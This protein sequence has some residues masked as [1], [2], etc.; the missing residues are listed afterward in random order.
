[1][2]RRWQPAR[3]GPAALCDCWELRRFGAMGALD[4]APTDAELRAG[5]D[6]ALTH[7]SRPFHVIAGLSA[8]AARLVE[9]ST[10]PHGEDGDPARAFQSLV[11]RYGDEHR[12]A[13]VGTYFGQ[14]PR[15]EASD[16]TR[17]AAIHDHMTSAL[18][19]AAAEPLAGEAGWNRDAMWAR[20]RAAESEAAAAVRAGS[21][22]VDGEPIPGFTAV[23]GDHRRTYFA[24]PVGGAVF[25]HTCRWDGATELQRSHDYA[26]ID[27]AFRH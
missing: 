10:W 3:P 7:E 4:P 2:L 15:E 6:H 22:V 1:M 25:V 16:Q 13:E 21:L 20:I 24:V 8:G 9:H 19:L 18:G 27:H 26:S 11:V 17:D 12:W 23:V 5:L 14:L